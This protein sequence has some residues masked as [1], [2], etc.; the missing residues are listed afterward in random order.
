MNPDSLKVGIVI[1]CHGDMGDGMRNAA[2][3]IVGP[4]E[5]L[6][7]VGIFPGM[8]MEDGKRALKKAIRKVDQSVGAIVLT[9]LPGGTPCNITISMISDKL[10][11]ITGFNLPMLVKILMDRLRETNPITLTTSATEHGRKHIMNATDML[12]GSKD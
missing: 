10:Q 8:G 5:A 3:L 12:Q 6:E 11:M 7:V 4:Q 9:D 2:E 1:C